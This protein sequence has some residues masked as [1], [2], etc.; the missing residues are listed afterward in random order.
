MW[1]F[2]SSYALKSPNVSVCKKAA[3]SQCDTAALAS[4]QRGTSCCPGVQELA[5]GKRKTNK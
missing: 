3:L 5:M 1:L 4:R 2:H